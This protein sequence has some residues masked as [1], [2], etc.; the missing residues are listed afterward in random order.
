[1]RVITLSGQRR[2][3]P[4]HVNSLSRREGDDIHSPGA[5]MTT[6][7]SLYSHIPATDRLLRDPHFLTVV[8]RFGHTATVDMLRLLQEEVREHIQAENALPDW[9]ADWGQEAERRLTANAQG[10]LRPVFNLTGTVL[11]TNLGRAQQAEEAV[12]AVAQAM[13]SPVTLEYDLDGAGRGHRDRA[14]ADLLCQLTGAEDAC[15]VNNNAAAV[16]LMLAATASGKRW[17]SRA[18]NWW[19]LAVRSASRTSCVRRAVRCT[20]WAPPIA[21][22]QKII[23]RR[24]TKI[25]RC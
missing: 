4:S 18:A 25:P 2:Y 14:L 22:M 23:A 7:R 3:N 1:M 6:H 13:R 17:W 10:A 8:D 19:R 24:S 20:K 9:C 12:A 21:P 16:L 15:I 11:H 5:S